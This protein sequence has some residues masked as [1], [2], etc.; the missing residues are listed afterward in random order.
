MLLLK[1][2]NKL[3]F[4]VNLI[5]QHSMKCLCHKIKILQFLQKKTL[6]FYLCWLVFFNIF[7]INNIKLNTSYYISNFLSFFFNKQKL[8]NYIVNIVL[9]S[10]NTLINVNNIKGNPKFF[11]SA[12]MLNLKKKQKIKQP[13]AIITILRALLSKLK[14][15]KTTPVSLHFNNLFST[16]QSYVFKLLKHKLFIKSIISY[17]YYPHNG[18]RLKKKKRIKLRTRTRKL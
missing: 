7:K 13:K 4:S 18:C 8:I 16:Q 17:K 3:F 10:T 6:S 14:I 9:S 12:G 15:Y 11:Y 2:T 1:I 5:I